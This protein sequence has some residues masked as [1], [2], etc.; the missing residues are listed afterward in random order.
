M[1]KTRLPL[2]ATPLPGAP[3]EDLRG[4]V[5]I[6]TGA[7]AKGDGEGIGRATALLLAR[8]G[9]RLGLVDRHEDRLGVTAARIAAAGG[10]SCTVVTDV[11]DPVACNTAVTS[12]AKR[13][14]RIDVLINNVGIP[15]PSGDV[16]DLSLE[17][18][19]I[20]LRTNLSSM[21]YMSRAAVPHMRQAGGG[22]I[23][24]VSST[25]GLIA[26][27]SE[28]LLYPT[29]KGAA[30]ALTRTMARQHG[31]DGIRVNCV[32]PGMVNTP[33]STDGVTP[34]ILE[35]RA[36]LAFLSVEGTAWDVANAIL[37]LASDM[38]RWVTGT[39]LVVD[40]GFLAGGG[41]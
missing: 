6:V 23:V 36:R 35:Q 18:W 12:I 24:H 4:K 28:R 29:T 21:V 20:G 39:T 37:Y 13:F 5:A 2:E 31:P 30:L 15:G 11:A 33:K 3:C 32:V 10:E 25:A 8:H 1:A 40:G 14:G 17:E 26:A 9:A 34:E 38:A 22:A 41:V 19:D 16:A 7:G 27:Q